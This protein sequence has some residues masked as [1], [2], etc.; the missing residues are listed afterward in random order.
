MTFDGQRQVA[1]D[2]EC[3]YNVVVE[4]RPTLIGCEFWSD[5]VVA[6]SDKKFTGKIQVFSALLSWV[7]AKVVSTN[8]IR[9]AAT[10]S[11][12]KKSEKRVGGRGRLSRP[13][14]ND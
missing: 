2:S 12:Q 9:R 7:L 3:R 14:Q 6:D 11:T 8:A 4:L 1:W 13:F 10:S 5:Y